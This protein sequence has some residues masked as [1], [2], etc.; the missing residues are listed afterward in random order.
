MVSKGGV[1]LETGIWLK[2]EQYPIV[3]VISAHILTYTNHKKKYNFKSLLAIY[4]I[5][6]KAYTCIQ[7]ENIVMRDIFKF[8]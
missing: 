5:V 4:H 7:F 1:D 3:S 6:H 8:L 2:P